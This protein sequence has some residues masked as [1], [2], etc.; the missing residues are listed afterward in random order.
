MGL[1]ARG[2]QHLEVVNGGLEIGLTDTLD[3]Q[4]HRVLAG[5]EHAVLTGAIVLELEEN[6]TVFQLVNILGLAC[7]NLLHDLAPLAKIWILTILGRERAALM[8]RCGF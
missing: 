6:V 2:L 3:G 4:S 5:I 1:D 7:V 8:H